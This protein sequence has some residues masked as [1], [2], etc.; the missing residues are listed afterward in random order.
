[1][2]TKPVFK[3]GISFHTF[4]Q[5]F[6][7]FVYSFEDLMEIASELGGGVEIV[8]PSNHRGFPEV[9]DEFERAFK[10]SVERY[11][12]IPTSYGSY[13]DPFMLPDRDLTPD[14]IYE[15]TVPQLKGAAK[16]GF[17]VVRLQYFAH[18][19]AE[20]LVPIAEKLDLKMGYELHTPLEIE[21]P[22]VL[23]LREQIAKLG[24]DRLG[25]IPDFGIFA[26][27]I[28]EH[29]LNA[30]RRIGV[31]EAIIASAQTLW[32]AKTS[33]HDA[34][35]AVEAMGAD[36]EGLSWIN[37]V[38]GSFGHS[39][40]AA[41]AEIKDSIVHCHGKFYSIVDGD[42]PDLRYEEVVKALLEIGYSG[43][44]STEYEGGPAD[45][46]AVARAH[47]SM[48]NGYIEKLTERQAL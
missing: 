25:L 42:E 19:A 31:P 9:T 2:A 28:S 4:V 18:V 46:F 32:K 27:S 26:R 5:E 40:P 34:L 29:H 17:P 14:E 35:E 16:L 36:E 45:T 30:G 8:G 23:M 22:T 11:G 33:K 13:Q 1:M 21:S 41:L 7:S 24:S 37:M 39:E 47:Q 12:L 3:V 6:I 10:S 20:R 44:V 48:M 38:W 15:Y 43:W